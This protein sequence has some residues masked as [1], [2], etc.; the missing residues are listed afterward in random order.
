MEIARHL[1]LWCYVE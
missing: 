1:Y